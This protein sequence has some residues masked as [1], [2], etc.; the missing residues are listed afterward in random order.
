MRVCS[1]HMAMA[2]GVARKR[3]MDP[4]FATPSD[5]IGKMSI[6]INATTLTPRALPRRVTMAVRQPIAQSTQMGVSDFMRHIIH[7]LTPRAQH[8]ITKRTGAEVIRLRIT[9]YTAT[10]VPSFSHVKNPIL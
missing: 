4:L 7:P 1:T 2:T 9:V 10:T 3:M 5:P 6:S 8:S